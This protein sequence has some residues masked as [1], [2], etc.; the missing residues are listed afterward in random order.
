MN[1]LDCGFLSDIY[2]DFAGDISASNTFPCLAEE[3]IMEIN[4]KIKS[5]LVYD[6]RRRSSH[7]WRSSSMWIYNINKNKEITGKSLLCFDRS[8]MHDQFSANEDEIF[9]TYLLRCQLS[10]FGPDSYNVK[11][12]EKMKVGN[13]DLLLLE[14]DV[15]PRN[16]RTEEIFVQSC[17]SIVWLKTLNQ[18][19][20]AYHTLL[21]QHQKRHQYDLQ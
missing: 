12:S 11:V 17:M 5:L 4:Q 6:T 1:N 8:T 10:L 15:E 19:Y 20:G 2:A 13:G 14:Y 16:G 7:D 18:Y 9:N 3:N 21:S